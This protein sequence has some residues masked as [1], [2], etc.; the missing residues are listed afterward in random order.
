VDGPLESVFGPGHIA[1]VVARTTTKV[2]PCVVEAVK[3]F[4][5]ASPDA[6]PL[7]LQP[8]VESA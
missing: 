1:S 7:D 4:P 6:L 3:A 8:F 5:V 2:A